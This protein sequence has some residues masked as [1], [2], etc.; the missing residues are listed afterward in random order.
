M[1]IVIAAQ[2]KARTLMIADSCMTYNDMKLSNM[3]ASK[4][5]KFHHFLIGVAGNGP[6]LEVL[7]TMF[8]DTATGAVN[9]QF[10]ISHISHVLKFLKRYG[11]VFRD[12]DEQE[13][14]NSS[15]L[16]ITTRN[17]IWWTAGDTNAYEVANYWAIGCG[18]SY[19]LGSLHSEWDKKL[20]GEDLREVMTHAADAACRFRPD[21]SGP[22]DW[23]EFTE[24]G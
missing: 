22:Y 4:I 16:L 15:E 13:N 7:D 3:T 20:K 18:A 1:T 8:Y 23:G 5:K 19:S 14:L 11:D 12:M 6:I 2:D 24:I 21:C 9:R 10:E 17:R